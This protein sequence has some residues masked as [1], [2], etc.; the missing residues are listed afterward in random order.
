MRVTLPSGAIICLQSS[1]DYP[2]AGS[3]VDLVSLDT[4]GVFA[5]TV[6]HARALITPSMTLTE[7]TDVL[8]SKYVLHNNKRK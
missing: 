8:A 7:A 4:M 2:S 1:A 6:E 3:T 5:D